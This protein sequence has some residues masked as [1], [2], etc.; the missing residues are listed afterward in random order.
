MLTSNTLT[1]MTSSLGRGGVWGVI[2]TL[3]WCLHYLPPPLGID[4]SVTHN[5]MWTHQHC[6]GQHHFRPDFPNQGWN[7]ILSSRE[8]HHQNCVHWVLLHY[9]WNAKLK[10]SSLKPCHRPT[11][12]CLY[13]WHRCAGKKPDRVEDNPTGSTHSRRKHTIWPVCPHQLEWL[14]E[15]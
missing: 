6:C 8:C 1:T 15:E 14:R 5:N 12:V 11:S 3:I 9:Q 4:R 7:G 2:W 13:V 10:R